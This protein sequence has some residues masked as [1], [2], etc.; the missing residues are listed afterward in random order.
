M[1]N[2]GFYTDG[3]TVEEILNLGDDVL[4]TLSKRD[5]SRALRTVSLAANK[6]INRLLENA[7]KTK[8]GYKLKKNARQISLDALNNLTN[9]G[10][11]TAKFSVGDKTRNEMYAELSRARQFMK[12]KTSTI[13]GAESTRKGRESRIMGETSEQAVK[14]ATEAYKEKRRK[15][16]KK[17]T[18]KQAQAFEKKAR[19]AF[20]DLTSQAWSTYRKF[21]EFE[22]LDPH[23]HYAGST[24]VIALV[25]ERTVAG[26]SETEIIQKAHELYVSR[27][28][29]MISEIMDEMDND[30]FF[31]MDYEDL[32]Y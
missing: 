4:R 24:E 10:T 17:T 19:A 21:L 32:G 13:R 7:I 31:E 6:R 1:A 23:Q 11:Q 12:M 29:E 22:G 15:E 26:D 30:N 20:S 16:G 9:D 18:K 3:M 8:D 27:Y 25:G 5:M 2:K 14:R 28:E